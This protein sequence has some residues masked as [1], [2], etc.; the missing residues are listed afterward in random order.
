MKKSIFI[1][2]IFF[3]NLTFAQECFVFDTRPIDCINKWVILPQ[4]DNNDFT[5]GYLFLDDEF[6]LT[7]QIEGVFEVDEDCVFTPTKSKK[8]VRTKIEPSKILFAVIWK[9]KFSELQV[10]ETPSWQK[11]NKKPKE[12]A[13]FYFQ[14]GYI[15]NA[16][17]EHQKALV[18]LMQAR[19]LNQKIAN[20]DR[21]MAFT[22]NSLGMYDKAIEILLPLRDKRP[23]DAYIYRELI[24][25][26]TKSGKL[27]EAAF[28]LKH[29]MSVCKDKQYHGE[30]CLNVLFQA[31]VEDDKKIFNQYLRKARSLN[32]GNKKAL[33]LIKQMETEMKTKR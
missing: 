18:S 23:K 20:L 11:S 4:E 13:E 17:G 26:L 3:A 32:K 30:N 8:I 16:W 22:Y 25:A 28:N 10:P 7:L 21:E 2:F 27:K 5:F 12:N 24:F 1:T 6:N 33:E 19:E 9:E 29:S 14:W 15:Y 31:F